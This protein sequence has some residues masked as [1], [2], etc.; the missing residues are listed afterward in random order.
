MAFQLYDRKERNTQTVHW[1]VKRDQ[2]SRRQDRWSMIRT[3]SP[4][5][6]ENH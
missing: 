3:E 2:I 6:A 4:A 5:T 1:H